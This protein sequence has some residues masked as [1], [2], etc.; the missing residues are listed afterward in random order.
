MLFL[1]FV[2]IES[3]IRAHEGPDAR[4]QRPEMNDMEQGYSV[5]SEN[6]FTVF[7]AARYAGHSNQGAVATFGGRRTTASIAPKFTT[8]DCD[9]RPSAP[10]KFFT[11]DPN[12]RP[13]TPCQ[14]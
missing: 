10:A 14:H 7:S 11:P 13:S 5:E 9:D 8:Y 2:G 1:H 4:K 12:E 6:C 3:Q